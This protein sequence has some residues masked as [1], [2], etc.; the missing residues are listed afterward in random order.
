MTKFKK[1]KCVEEFIQI[2]GWM[3]SIIKMTKTKKAIDY[4]MNCGT[5]MYMKYD[6]VIVNRY[7]FEKEFTKE[8]KHYRRIYGVFNQAMAM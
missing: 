3:D 4:W 8:L 1:P 7:W 5:P 6:D 2:W